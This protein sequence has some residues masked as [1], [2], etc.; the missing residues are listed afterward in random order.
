MSHATWSGK[1]VSIR[2]VYWDESRKLG[3]LIDPVENTGVILVLSSRTLEWA[4][5]CKHATAL[6][7]EGKKKVDFK[8]D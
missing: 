8:R 2:K 7:F 1:R 6:A 3:S 5:A 4:F